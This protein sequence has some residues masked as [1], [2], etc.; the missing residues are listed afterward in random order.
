MKTLAHTSQRELDA[1]SN[2][3]SLAEKLIDLKV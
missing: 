1:T 3:D 2:I